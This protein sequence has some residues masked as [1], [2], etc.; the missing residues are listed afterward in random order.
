VR[1]E[2][3]VL[4]ERAG[5]EQQLDALA[6]GQL[7]LLVLLVDARLAAAQLGAGDLLLQELDLLLDRQG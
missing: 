1:L 3:V 6:G 7:A 4:A 5:I 2:A